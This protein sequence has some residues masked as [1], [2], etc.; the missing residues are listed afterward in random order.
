VV[1]AVNVDGEIAVDLQ[2]AGIERTINS[3]TVRAEIP[4]N[5]CII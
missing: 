1:I 4:P 2:R 3:G 5:L